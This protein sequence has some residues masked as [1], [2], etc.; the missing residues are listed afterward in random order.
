MEKK[1]SKDQKIQLMSHGKKTTRILQCII[2][3][4]LSKIGGLPQVTA[5]LDSVFLLLFFFFNFTGWGS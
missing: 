5:I 3:I 4:K 1:K 2:A